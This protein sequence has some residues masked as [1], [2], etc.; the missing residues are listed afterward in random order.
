MAIE[1][2]TSDQEIAGSLPPV[3]DTKP[4]ISTGGYRLVPVFVTGAAISVCQ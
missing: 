3:P 4:H 2:L 1:R